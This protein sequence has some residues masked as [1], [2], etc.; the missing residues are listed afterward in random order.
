MDEL[1]ADYHRLI[2]KSGNPVGQT[3]GEWNRLVMHTGRLIYGKETSGHFTW[4]E[5]LGRVVYKV[6]DISE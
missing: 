4:M 1:Q 6:G 5:R 3:P 2:E